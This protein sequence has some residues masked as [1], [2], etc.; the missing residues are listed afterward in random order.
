MKR[1][2]KGVLIFVRVKTRASKQEITLTQDECLVSVKAAP[3]HGKANNE[4]VRIFAKH[5]ALPTS[6]ITIITGHKSSR[7]VLLV[8]GVELGQVLSA[9]QC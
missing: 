2:P 9:L 4:L 8:E 1:H 6:R 3:I 7:K 5:L